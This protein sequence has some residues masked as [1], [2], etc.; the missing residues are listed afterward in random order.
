MPA[1]KIPKEILVPVFDKMRIKYKDVF[2]IKAF[3]EAL[4]YWSEDNNWVDLEEKSDRYERFYGERVR[5]DGSKEIWI[6]W[7]MVKEPR[8]IGK[9]GKK[10]ALT[11]Y[12]DFDFHSPFINVTEVIKDGKKF[13]ADKGEVDL[14]I[15][16]YIE[17][18]YKKEFEGSPILGFFR[19]IFA[20]RIYSNII[21]ER[22]RELY[23]EVYAL[24]NFIKQWF[25]LKR[26]QPYI[27]TKEPFYASEAYPSHLK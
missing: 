8:A 15:R 12:L 16:A 1:K 5:S 20:R 7:R 23:Q 6:R 25:K 17:E 18:N 26:Y 3:Y 19:G 11:Y 2:S 24:Q 14:I 13:K 21:G 9:L 10:P 27:G 22:K 4:H